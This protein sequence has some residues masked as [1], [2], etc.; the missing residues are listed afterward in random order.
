MLKETIRERETHLAQPWVESKGAKIWDEGFEVKINKFV[1]ASHGEDKKDRK[2]VTGYV[3]FVGDMPYKWGSERK[4][5]TALSTYGAEFMAM[6]T[7]V[8]EVT[9]V[10]YMVRC[11]GVHVTKP[12]YILGDNRSV[13]I[14]STVHSS[15]LK[16]KHVAIAYHLTREATANGTVHPLKTKSEWNF[17]DLLTK[18]LAC[19]PFASL[20]DGIL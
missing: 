3:I 11:L 1:D 10:R 7:A 9:A 4:K 12:S 15:L 13:I 2:S 17:A 8:E 19:K 6:K 18:A 20:V 16:K 14:Q 5:L